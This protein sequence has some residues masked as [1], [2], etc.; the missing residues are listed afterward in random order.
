MI[1]L[2]EMNKIMSKYF[3]DFEELKRILSNLDYNLSEGELDNIGIMLRN[4]TDIYDFERYPLIDNNMEL[5]FN[6]IL[7]LYGADFMRKK[8]LKCS[9]TSYYNL[10]NYFITGTDEPTVVY[11]RL[12]NFYRIIT[13]YFIDDNDE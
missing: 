1:Y 7:D 10:Y 5:L 13:I 2:K 9:Q 8:I 6:I 3:K 12:K 11:K 4:N